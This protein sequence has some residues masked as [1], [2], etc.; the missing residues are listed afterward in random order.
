MHTEILWTGSLKTRKL[1]KINW[2]WIWR[3][4]NVFQRNQSNRSGKRINYSVRGLPG[5]WGHI[6]CASEGLL[7]ASW[8]DIAVFSISTFIYLFICGVF[9]VWTW[10]LTS[11]GMCFT[12][13]AM[14]SSLQ[15]IQNEK[16]HWVL[17]ENSGWNLPYLWNNHHLS[18]GTTLLLN[19]NY[20]FPFFALLLT[21]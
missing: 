6:Q 16:L 3:F 1:K 14:A 2:V 21:L 7:N 17:S 12:T 15:L 19:G 20:S 11:W 13:A 4:G 10:G 8:M 9:L 18:A 5:Q